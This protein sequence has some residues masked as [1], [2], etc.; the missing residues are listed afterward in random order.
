MDELIF[1]VEQFPLYI[2]V[3]IRTAGLIGLVPIFRHTAIPQR[4][5]IALV[6]T[7]AMIILSSLPDSAWRE[8]VLPDTVLGWTFLVIREA[9]VG[10]LLGFVTAMIFN[11]VIMAGEIASRDMGLAVAA[12]F[13]PDVQMT[14]TPLSRL[15]I[16]IFSLFI[17]ALDVHH[18][19]ILALAQTYEFV[20]INQLNPGIELEGML[21]SMMTWLYMIG[22]KI[23]AP[24]M[25]ILFL[26]TAAIGIMSRAA[27]QVNILMI[28]FPIRIAVGLTILAF[29]VGTLGSNFQKLLLKMG[30]DMNTLMRLMV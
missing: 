10:I 28:S 16:V 3:L 21:I 20:P 22:V 6:S 12:E 25:A 18:W 17:L 19:F 24:V 2:I 30:E 29:S 9:S 14:I 15:Y 13:N 5:K 7:L 27:P 26:V 8:L 11:A 23:S 1:L 4:V